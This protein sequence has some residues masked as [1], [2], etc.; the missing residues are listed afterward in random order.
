[1][2]TAAPFYPHPRL[3]ECLAGGL[4][5]THR[6]RVVVQRWGSAT[7]LRVG[8]EIDA[9]NV[10]TW[11]CLLHEAA[12]AAAPG[13]LVI[14][15]DQ[16]DFLGICGFAALVDLSRQRHGRNIAVCL[17]SNRPII[18]RIIAVCQWRDALP[19]YPNVDAAVDAHPEVNTLEL[20]Q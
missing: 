3:T 1:M 9:N 7:V 16:L 13:L 2:I 11:K 5:H 10:A 8:G 20:T 15:T 19:V 18:E 12:D 6:F 17:V 14:D 4:Q